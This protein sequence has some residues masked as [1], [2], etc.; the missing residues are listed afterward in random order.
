MFSALPRHP[1]KRTSRNA[2][3]MSVSCRLCCKSRKSNDFEN[4][5]KVDF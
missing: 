3:G 5:A 1:E 2:V 4:L